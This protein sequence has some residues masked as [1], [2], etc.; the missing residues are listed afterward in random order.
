MLLPGEIRSGHECGCECECGF[1]HG[2][3]SRGHSS[4]GNE[5]ASDSR[6][7]HKSSE[8]PNIKMFRVQQ[9]IASKAIARYRRDRAK[10]TG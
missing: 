6:K 10:E 1:A 8:G 4:Y 7:S 5:S 2:E 3:V 9:G